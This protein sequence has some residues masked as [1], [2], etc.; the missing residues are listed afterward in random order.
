MK[1]IQVHAQ[2]GPDVLKLQEVPK[3]AL[4]AGQ[5]LVRIEAAGVNYV[6]V[7]KRSAMSAQYKQPLPFILG[8]EAAGI[9]E[10]V[11][12]DVKDMAKGDR[13]A[14]N[15]IDGSYAEYQAVPAAKVI[16][17]PSGIDVKTA[18]A[19]LLQGMTAHYLASSTYPLKSG[20]WCLVHAAA[21]GV[22]LLLTQ[23]AK[24]RGA[25]VIG[26]VSTPEKAKL[27]KQAGADEVINYTSQDFEA[28]TKRITGG[29]G[30]QAVYDSV[31]KTTFDKSLN[32]LAPR[33]VLAL[34]GTSSGPVPPVDLSQLGPKGSLFITRPSLV[35]HTLTREELVQRSG[36]I[37]G[38][39]KTGRLKVR[40]DQTWPLAQAADAHR[41][42]ES[43][44]STGKLLLIP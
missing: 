39:V 31:G 9:V 34:Y 12:P 23:V 36:D 7:Y 44:Q 18:A 30:V 26:T 28:E 11:A 14:F 40:I 29:K 32:C 35:H 27:A 16:K 20:D 10:A 42:L 43:R 5:V 41:K 6:D 24:M 25:R 38:W 3:P 19:V 15:G 8:Q 17:L 37:F 2:G 22:G 21:G 1:A 4:S 33:G 13:V